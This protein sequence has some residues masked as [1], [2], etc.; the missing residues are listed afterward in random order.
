MRHP[1]LAGGVPLRSE[2]RAH[3][4]HRG[5]RGESTPCAYH[6]LAFLAPDGGSG[7]GPDGIRTRSP[8]GARRRALFVG[9]HSGRDVP[10]H[11]LGCLLAPLVHPG[12]A[13][14]PWPF[15]TGS[16]FSGRSPSMN[17]QLDASLRGWRWR[18]IPCRDPRCT[19]HVRHPLARWRVV[20]GGNGFEP[21]RS[22]LTDG[23][24]KY[25][26]ARAV[27]VPTVFTQQA[28]RRTSASHQ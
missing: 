3:A 28:L 23:G 25:Q 27:H 18:S 1:T 20:V 21:P 26:S 19:D 5:I 17:P 22:K 8:R 11:C 9:M 13:L 15:Q 14:R 16:R 7:R 2:L 4:D 6:F 10:C 24:S 12:C